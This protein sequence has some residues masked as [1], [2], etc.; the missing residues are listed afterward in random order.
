MGTVAYSDVI[1]DIALQGWKGRVWFS[2]RAHEHFQKYCDEQ[3]GIW[4]DLDNAPAL[5]LLCAHV[6]AE[7][8][9]RTRPAPTRK[10]VMDLNQVLALGLWREGVSMHSLPK[11]A[12]HALNRW[13]YRLARAA[14]ATRQ[15]PP[16]EQIQ[17]SIAAAIALSIELT[18]A[19]PVLLD[20]EYGFDDQ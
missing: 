4:D 19:E 13:W 9:R 11:D 14:S 17:R 12:H 7:L 1:E 5:M 20:Q 2:E 8:V 16:F 3:G 10:I 18:Y 15:R 6:T